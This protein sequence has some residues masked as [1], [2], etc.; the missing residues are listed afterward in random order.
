MV[1]A[2]FFSENLAEKEKLSFCH[3]ELLYGNQRYKGC[4]VCVQNIYVFKWFAYD[5]IKNMTLQIMTNWSK[6]LKDVYT[7]QRVS[8][9]NLW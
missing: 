7:I 3:T 8:V 2:T 9:L 1:I 5:A 6:L 4:V